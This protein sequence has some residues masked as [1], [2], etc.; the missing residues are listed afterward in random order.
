MKQPQKG[1]ATGRPNARWLFLAHPDAK[2]FGG[3]RGLSTM[4]EKEYGAGDLGEIFSFGFSS[5]T[6]KLRSGPQQ[7]R[8]APFFGAAERTP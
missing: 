7:S 6:E 1:D 5:L 8:G 4:R 2:F 3:K